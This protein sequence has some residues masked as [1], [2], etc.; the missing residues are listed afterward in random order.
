M[1]K[2]RVTAS[3]RKRV[4]SMRDSVSGSA[5]RGGIMVIPRIAAS[6]DVW[7]AQALASQEKLV[8][9]ARD[10]IP[11][12]QHPPALEDVTHRHKVTR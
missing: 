4:A 8:A 12:V 5:R 2:L 9:D 1:R 3:M 6:V 11:A 10:S 7:E